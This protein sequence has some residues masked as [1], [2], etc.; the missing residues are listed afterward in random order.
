MNL[1]QNRTALWLPVLVMASA[2]SRQDEQQ[3]N[4]AETTVATPAAETT[5]SDDSA[6]PPWLTSQAGPSY[7]CPLTEA[8]K[9]A[10]R[11][12]FLMNGTTDARDFHCRQTGPFDWDGKK[13]YVQRIHSLTTASQPEAAR[14]V[15]IDAG[16]DAPCLFDGTRVCVDPVAKDVLTPIPETGTGRNGCAVVP[17][18]KFRKRP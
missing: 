6:L 13:W 4:A 10:D 7:A 16:L 12:L 1:R 11:P 2:C 17:E 18:P 5:A 8:D 15:C 3:S 14:K 9:T